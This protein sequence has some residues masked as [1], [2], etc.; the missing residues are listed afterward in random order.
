MV[1]MSPDP[2]AGTKS[3]RAG[4]LNDWGHA[5]RNSCSWQGTF[6]S[7]RWSRS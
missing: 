4:Q 2:S 1:K 5:G 6:S 3:R 7:D